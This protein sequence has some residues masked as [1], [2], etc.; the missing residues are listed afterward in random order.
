[1]NAHSVGPAGGE[2]DLV[3]GAGERVGHQGRHL[4]SLLPALKASLAMV[5]ADMA[6]G[7]PA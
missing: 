5:M 6:L 7:Q 3:A 2:Y 1:M 4:V